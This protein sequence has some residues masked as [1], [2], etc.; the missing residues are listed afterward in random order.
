[1]AIVN[2]RKLNDHAKEKAL[3]RSAVRLF[4]LLSLLLI[5]SAVSVLVPVAVVWLFDAIGLISLD[6]VLDMLQR[7]DFLL[8]AT[9]IGFATF[10]TLRRF[11]Q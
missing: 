1:M 4:K 10:F 8:A 11:K 3:Q 6:A 2:D 7:W 5:G 9:V